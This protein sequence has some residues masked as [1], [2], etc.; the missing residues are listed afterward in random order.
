[1]LNK[2]QAAAILSLAALGTAMPATLDTRQT[3]STCVSG[4][5]IIV[6]RASTEAQGEGIIGTVA[7][8]IEAA[9]PGSDSVAVVYPALLEPYPPSEEAGTSAMTALVQEYVASCP[10][11]KIVLLGYSQGAQIVGDVLCGTSESGFTTTAP[12]A[13]QYGKN[14]VAAVQ[15]GDPSHVVG[16]SYNKGTSTHNGLFPRTNEAGCAPYVSKI[17]SYC[18]TGDE[19]CD[20]GTSLLD[21]LD[22]VE[23]YGTAATQFVVSKAG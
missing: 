3:S 18:D 5:H 10:N 9:I 1:M 11:S 13:S 4:V 12:L 23:L 7:T 15:M 8:E 2:I 17:A 6:A 19:F 14:V 20:S 16:Q 21:H 22:Y